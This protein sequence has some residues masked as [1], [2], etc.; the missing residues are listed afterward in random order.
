[1]IMLNSEPTGIL[2]MN[3]KKALLIFFQR[4]FVPMIDVRSRSRTYLLDLGTI[5]SNFGSVASFAS[6]SK[7]ILDVVNGFGVVVNIEAMDSVEGDL[8]LCRVDATNVGL[9]GKNVVGGV[10]LSLF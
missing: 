7:I 10:T 4:P 6:V 1:M 3:L 9:V 2:L 8:A 5:Y